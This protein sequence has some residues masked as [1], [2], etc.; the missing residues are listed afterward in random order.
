[1][2]FTIELCVIYQWIICHL[3]MNFRVL[4]PGVVWYLLIY[5]L[6]LNDVLLWLYHKRLYF[7]VSYRTFVHKMH[8]LSVLVFVLRDVSKEAE[9]GETNY[10]WYVK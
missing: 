3:P 2:P 4:P 6:W 5:M 7:I 1:M 9:A 10:F 8:F